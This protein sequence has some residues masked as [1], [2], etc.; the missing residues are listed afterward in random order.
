MAEGK[1]IQCPN[2]GAEAKL[3]GNE[4]TC[5]N[6]DAIYKITKTGEAK[7]KQL[8][9]LEELGQRVAALEAKGGTSDS[10]LPVIPK[11]DTETEQEIEPDDGDT[12][13]E[14]A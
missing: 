6:C 2:C 13:S 1:K 12:P 3:V 9:P 14:F 5:L 8:G 7:V 4:I 10:V 11:G